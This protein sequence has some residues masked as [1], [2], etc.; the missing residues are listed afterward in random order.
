MDQE[1]TDELQFN[2]EEVEKSVQEKIEL[3]LAG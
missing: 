1:N 3:H 2:S